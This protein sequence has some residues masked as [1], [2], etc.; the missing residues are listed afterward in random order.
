MDTTY[1]IHRP[2]LLRVVGLTCGLLALQIVVLC[3]LA[4]VGGAGLAVLM[5]QIENPLVVDALRN[6]LLGICTVASYA[7][8]FGVHHWYL[9]R[10]G[11][12]RVVHTDTLLSEG[13]RVSAADFVPPTVGN[14]LSFYLHILVR[15][16][17]YSFVLL[18]PLFLLGVIAF[19]ALVGFVSGAPDLSE[20]MVITT[21]LGVLM[22]PI[23]LVAT[24]KPYLDMLKTTFG[25]KQFVYVKPV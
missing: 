9:G 5:G 2:S 13:A 10:P 25:G 24:V 18:L 4:V 7:L 16:F 14:T 21:V 3:V 8:H 17:L 23:T 6:V 12:F 1:T 19:G 15:S 22:L 20:V 11:A